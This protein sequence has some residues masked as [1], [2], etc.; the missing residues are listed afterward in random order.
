MKIFVAGASGVLGRAFIRRAIRDGHE[1]VGM[2]RSARGAATIVQEG[3]QSVVAD[4]YDRDAVVAAVGQAGPDA[5]LHLLTDLAGGDSTSNARI[6]SVGT[7]NLADAALA[8]GVGQMV[9]ESI[10]WV[11]PSASSP[12]DEDDV[13]DLGAA[14]PR[15]TT[16]EGVLSLETTVRTMPAGRLLRFGQLYGP[17]TWFAPDGRFADA[18]R[19]GTLPATETVASFI[20]VEDAAEAAVRAL[21]WP[22]G[23]WNIVDDDPAP[24]TDWVP[25]FAARVGAPKPA[26][27]TVGDIGR[28][29]DNARLHEMGFTLSHPTWRDGL[30]TR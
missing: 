12:A 30:G 16:I 22:A 24:G 8:A 19:T 9:A 23:T 15:R 2:T 4:A 1:I 13:L 21:E 18:A 20:H 6:R 17:G 5:V 26:L 14:E 11:Y 29:V 10:S 28:P 27:S 25:I 7:R 3:A